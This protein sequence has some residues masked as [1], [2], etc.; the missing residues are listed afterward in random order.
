MSA[1]PPAPQAGRFDDLRARLVSA[2][3]MLAVGIAE[4]WLGGPSFALLVILLTAAMLWELASITAP[5]RRNTP[6][7]VAGTGAAAL[8]G[9]L[10]LPGEAAPALLLAPALVLALTPRRDR[11]L[12][13]AWGAAVMLAGFGLV[14]LREGAG[15]L[16]VFW[17]ILVVIASDVAGYFVGRLLGGPKFWPAVSPRKTWSGTLAGWIAAAAVGAGFVLAGCAGG[18]LLL[19]SPLVAFAGQM[20][21]IAESWIK[22][23][24]GVKDASRLI[25]G[26][27]G[28]MDRFDALTGATLA[29][30]LLGA[31]LPQPLPLPGMP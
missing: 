24:A 12:S 20:G 28:V 8:A 5:A 10:A 3:V 14:S 31:A 29:L 7:A 27:G 18:W 9:A 17:L 16:A 6:L 22:R 25:P 23:R 26:H 15:T 13:A 21:D 30:T 4:I 1:P 2:V 11:R 19:L